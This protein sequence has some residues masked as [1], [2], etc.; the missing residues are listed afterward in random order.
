MRGPTEA[1]HRLFQG[2][3]HEPHQVLGAHPL[4]IGGR[5]GVVVRA[6]H[7]DATRA[8]CLLSGG[9]TL[10]MVAIE[11][12]LFA[13]FVPGEELPLAYRLRFHFAD[14]K[15][16]ERGD[17]YRFLPTVGE[18]DAHLFGE[19]N[20]RQL[21]R[22][23]GANL[24][25][26]D[27]ESGT[28][29][30]VWAPNARRVS[31]I[32]DFNGWDGR[33]SPMRSLGSSGIWELFV[34]DVAPG[35]LYKFEIK[36][37]DGGLR[38]KA[39]PLAQLAELPPATAS[40][41][42]ESSHVWRD[43]KWMTER[44]TQDVTRRPMN[45]YE[46]H[47]GSWKRVPEEGNRSLNYREAAVQLVEHCKRLG[48]THIE[49]M[50]VAEHPF[51]GSWGYQVTSYFAPS[52]RY[53]SPDDFRWLVDHCHQNGIGVIIDWVPA[54][55]PKDDFA[56]RRFD[57][58]ALYEHE[59]PRLGEHPD[60]GTLIFN[61][62]RPEVRNF[63]L[64][65]ALYW[66]VDLHVDGLR[67]DAVASMLYLDYSRAEGEWLPNEHGGRENIAAIEFLKATNHIIREEVPGAFTIAEE[68]TSW[69][70]VT[71]DARE[72]GLGFT[73]KWNMGW[74]HDT[75]E[76]FRKDPVHRG[77]HQN[78]LTF[79]MI[80]EFHERFINSISH[81][82]VVHGKGSLY[83][84]M[85]GDHW[86]KLANLR[87]LHAYQYTRPG[88]QLVFMGN[89]IGQEREWNHD[90]SVDWHLLEEPDRRKLQVFFEAL[91]RLYAGTPAFWENDPNPYSFEWIDCSDSANCVFSFLR[92]GG[93]QHVLVVM[94][95]T[96]VPRMD[97]RVGAPEPGSY[98]E[99]LSTDD[100]AFGGSDVE[101]A[102]LVE[103]EEVPAHGRPQSL[104]LTLPPLGLLV[105]GRP[106][107]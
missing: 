24:R 2:D 16:W 39:D 8:E 106:E 65:S 98:V 5:S 88:K 95:M 99:L 92:R 105:L 68:S 17:P 96:P 94:N 104:R 77:Y 30:A 11:K 60:W 40:V 12:G 62:G 56:L 86:Q 57:G 41:V 14:G 47:L 18:V 21:W 70:G 87:L 67:V 15:S 46:V 6:F 72:G 38:F 69:A 58:T 79:S 4:S 100:V 20:H 91:G 78:Q 28:A 10:G 101:T 32:A 54:H 31:L 34:P 107:P 52:T 82:E 85:P 19:G 13:V 97:Y 50:P 73:F 49:L 103:T 26:I 63:L 81:D 55:F 66:L 36:T 71:R 75:L 102:S 23:L 74:M 42:S 7:P 3:H 90:G 51:F 29:F 59:D 33:L 76:Y 9:R 44:G 37:H 35:A 25:T 48:F 84:K 53:G 83:S 64:A 27:G 45:I 93:G 1:V 43:G 80:Y 22:V 89:E 61:F